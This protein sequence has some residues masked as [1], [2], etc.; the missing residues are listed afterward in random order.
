MSDYL[1]DWLFGLLGVIGVDLTERRKQFLES[2]IHLYQRTH[3][4]VHYETLANHIGVSKWTAYDMLR[5]LEKQGFITRR[6]AIRP[7][8]MGR[9]QIVFVPTAQA[10][11]LFKRPHHVHS[12]EDLIAIKEKVLQFLH[13]LKDITPGKAIQRI[14]GEMSK[15]E[16]GVIFCAYL[17]GLLLVY[18]RTLNTNTASV[19]ASLIRL[20]PGREVR[21]TMFVGVVLG[22]VVQSIEDGSGN[23]LVDLAGRYL[24]TLGDLTEKEREVLADFL[25][26]GLAGSLAG[27]RSEL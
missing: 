4:P 10:E 11:V 7:G 9:S 12:E 18:L 13:E 23:E 25:D 26:E 24:K 5:Q 20:A 14:K 19:V 1:R 17:I 8:E 27:G 15:I 21:L 6:Y 22:T 3:L 2:L 16:A